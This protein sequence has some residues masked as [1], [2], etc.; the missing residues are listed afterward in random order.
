VL[1]AHKVLPVLMVQR[2]HKAQP[3]LLVQVIQAQLDLKDPLVQTV[4]LALLEQ[5]QQVLLVK[6]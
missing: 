3:A 1:Q 2:V 4:Q 6:E 5:E